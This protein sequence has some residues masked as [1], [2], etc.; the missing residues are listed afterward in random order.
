MNRIFK[1]FFNKRKKCYVVTSENSSVTHNGSAKTIALIIPIIALVSPF[2]PVYSVTFGGYVNKANSVYKDADGN[3]LLDLR[4]LNA[5]NG[6]TVGDG[7]VGA[8]QDTVSFGSGRFWEPLGDLSESKIFFLNDA[9]KKFEVNRGQGAYEGYVWVRG[10]YNEVSKD[11]SGKTIIKTKY[12]EYTLCAGHGNC[13]PGYEN[14]KNEDL[15]F[16]K[17]KEIFT[18]RTPSNEYTDGGAKTYNTVDTRKLV[19]VSAGEISATSTDAVNGKQIW[20]LQQKLGIASEYIS[21]NTT[22]GVASPITSA[23]AQGARATAVG[24]NAVASGSNSLA[25][26]HNATTSTTAS[27]SIAL[28]AGS[29]ANEADIVSV[30][31][32]TVKRRVTNLADGVSATDAATVGQIGKVASSSAKEAVVVANG[33]NTTVTLD[34]AGGKNTYK[35]NVA[36]DGQIASGNTGILTGD[37]VHK[38]FEEFTQTTN[39]QLSGFAKIDGSNIDID[40]GQW[41]TKLGSRSTNPIA[42]GNKHFVTGEQ[43][44]KETRVVVPGKF[45]TGG[46]TTVAQNLHNLDEAITE[47][48]MTKASKIDLDYAFN[49]NLNT[50]NAKKVQNEARK[51]VSVT[52]DDSLIQ[53]NHG[54]GD[55]VG[56]YTLSI[57]K[58][59]VAQGTTGV[60]LIT[61]EQ[62][63]NEVRP[64]NGTYVQKTQTTAQNLNALA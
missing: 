24:E 50:T 12:A 7:S 25:I 36:A 33:T 61:G 35:V 23:K 17:L 14:I 26:G 63:F 15:T 45:I 32:D 48:V 20:E 5:D 6:P 53:V 21:V 11:N 1:S 13:V 46:V 38:K 18:T 3:K 54:E 30:G 9:D 55:Q 42:E 59:S 64:T 22:D 28:G 49:F 34:T 41:L 62:I 4:K 47:V 60:G 44:A 10:R 27:N 31:S 2:Q 29:Q 52:S 19:N 37:T 40:N 58:G 56:H 8:G 39:T 43:I 51:A 16:E 57:H